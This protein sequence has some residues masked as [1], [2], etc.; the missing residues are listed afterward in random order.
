MQG[1]R[2]FICYLR[3]MGRSEGVT[4]AMESDIAEVSVQGSGSPWPALGAYP[5]TQFRR[6]LTWPSSIGR[7][8]QVRN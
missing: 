6:L 5:I 8:R 1:S 2:I 3:F 4:G 7:W